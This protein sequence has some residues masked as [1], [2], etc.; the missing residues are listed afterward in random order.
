VLL[1]GRQ[2]R[3]AKKE[4][5]NGYRTR[6]YLD[7]DGAGEG[8]KILEQLADAHLVPGVPVL[9]PED[10]VGG[11]LVHDAGP[12]LRGRLDEQLSLRPL[13]GRGSAVPSVHHP[14]EDAGS[15][16]P[17]RV[18]HRG[19]VHPG[20]QAERPPCRLPRVD[21]CGPSLSLSPSSAPQV[22]NHLD[23]RIHGRW[24]FL[25]PI[26]RGG[27]GGASGPGDG[28]SCGWFET[29]RAEGCRGSRGYAA[30]EGSGEQ[31]RRCQPRRH[32]YLAADAG[33]TSGLVG[34]CGCA[35]VVEKRGAGG[36]QLP[37][38][39]ALRLETL[40][41]IRVRLTQSHGWV[42]GLLGRGT[43]DGHL[44]AH[45]DLQAGSTGETRLGASVVRRPFTTQNEKGR[46]GR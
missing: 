28:D 7:G 34:R 2:R 1:E 32:G 19:V 33:L 17:E 13:L 45:H 12:A 23:R 15:R 43:G 40:A 14:L 30:D 27:R 11:E 8:V 41:A 36:P 46:N 24:R 3:N 39:I 38:N 9:L 22:R 6:H 44:E 10:V 4:D 21:R 37:R 25:A 29:E 42:S 35:G 20:P 16:L 31:Q 26:S 18:G 5:R